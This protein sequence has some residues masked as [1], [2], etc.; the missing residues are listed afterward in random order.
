LNDG[1]DVDSIPLP[2]FTAQTLRTAG[3]LRFNVAGPLADCPIAP[4]RQ[5][6]EVDQWIDAREK[7]WNVG[8]D[9]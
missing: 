6:A 7:A 4:A 8:I 1:P 3:I 5:P 9:P 2:V